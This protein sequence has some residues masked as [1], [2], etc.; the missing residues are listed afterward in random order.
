MCII[1]HPIVSV[2]NGCVVVHAFLFFFQYIFLVYIILL[3]LVC[4]IGLLVSGIVMQI[5]NAKTASTTVLCFVVV[6]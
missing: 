5:K 2:D 6:K 4:V 1:Y 3:S